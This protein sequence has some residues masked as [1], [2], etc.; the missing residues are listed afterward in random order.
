MDNTPRE[1]WLKSGE[2]AIVQFLS[3]DPCVVDTHSVWIDGSWKTIPCQLTTQKHC[4]M[5][6]D[7][8]KKSWKAYFKILDYR[9]NWDKDKKKFK[10]DEQIEKFWGVGSGVADILDSLRLRRKKDLTELVLEVTKTGSGK[11]TTYSI[12]VA[13]DDDGV[14]LKP[15]TFKEKYPD[16]ETLVVDSLVPTDSYLDKTGFDTSEN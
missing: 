3:D 12:S 8:A 13:E 1:F 11:T 10:N 15:V 14:K 2:T 4:L 9:G 6:R 5:C 7:N 16:I